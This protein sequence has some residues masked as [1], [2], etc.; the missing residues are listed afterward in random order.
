MSEVRVPDN[1]AVLV[2]AWGITI[3][4]SLFLLGVGIGIGWVLFS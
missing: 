4:W 3:L 2:I 1:A